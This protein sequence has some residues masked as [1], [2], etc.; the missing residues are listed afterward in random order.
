MVLGFM[1]SGF[2]ITSLPKSGPGRSDRPSAVS[3]LNKPASAGY[4]S[5]TFE[6][7]SIFFKVKKGENFNHRNMFNISRIEI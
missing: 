1:V 4:L 2:H 3:R 5:E 6:K 7:Y